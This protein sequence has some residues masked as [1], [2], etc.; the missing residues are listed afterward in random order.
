M[1]QFERKKHRAKAYHLAAEV[2]KLQSEL[3]ALDMKRLKLLPKF[4]NE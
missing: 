3:A 1:N 4:G 2:E